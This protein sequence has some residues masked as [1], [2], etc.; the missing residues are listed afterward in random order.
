MKTKKKI[1]KNYKKWWQNV[2]VVENMKEKEIDLIEK[3]CW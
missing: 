2:V 1:D 3:D